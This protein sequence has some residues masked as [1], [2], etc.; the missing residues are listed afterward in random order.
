MYACVYLLYLVWQKV[1]IKVLRH[2]IK[3]FNKKMEVYMEK[4]ILKEIMR[5]CKN[6][7]EKLLV[8]LFS[9]TCIKAYHIGRINM[10]N[11]ILK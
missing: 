6:R 9:N 11:F 10:L 1:S 2:V 5:E 4:E 7:R 8:R 3:K